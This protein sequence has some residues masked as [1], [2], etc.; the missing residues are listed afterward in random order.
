[1]LLLSYSIHE[2]GQS[3]AARGRTSRKYIHLEGGLQETAIPAAFR[4][5]FPGENQAESLLARASTFHN[6]DYRTQYIGRADDRSL[7]TASILVYAK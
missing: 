4:G 1:M 2:S 7:D 5:G 6:N 3:H